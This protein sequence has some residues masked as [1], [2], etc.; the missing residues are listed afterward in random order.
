[1][2]GAKG[3]FRMQLFQ[4]IIHHATPATRNAGK[5][6]PVVHCFHGWD[7]DP[8]LI[9]QEAQCGPEANPK[10]RA[11]RST[12]TDQKLDRMI[13]QMQ[14]MNQQIAASQ[15]FMVSVIQ[16]AA[17]LSQAAAPS[18]FCDAS[19]LGGGLIPFPGWS[20]FSI[21]FSLSLLAFLPSLLSLVFSWLRRS[22]KVLSLHNEQWRYSACWFPP[23]RCAHHGCVQSRGLIW[24]V[25]KP[26]AFNANLLTACDMT[27]PS[28]TLCCILT[29]R[30]VIRRHARS[31]GGRKC[32]PSMNML[33]HFLSIPLDIAL[34]ITD[35]K[36]IFAVPNTMA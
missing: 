17:S 5:A 24:V 20:N 32:L 21:G 28:V 26:L 30:S 23:D 1:M 16:T 4:F 6:S 31:A 15:Q 3:L 11:P 19:S 10:H 13:E 2:A 34:V 27:L 33:R 35:D 8:A 22:R 12:N 18:S 9:L 36:A 7:P 25:P 29:R 14:I